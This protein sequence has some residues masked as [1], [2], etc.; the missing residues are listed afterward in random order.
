[1]FQETRMRK[2][3]F[4][5]FILLG[6]SVGVFAA[7]NESTGLKIVLG[8]IGAVAGAAIGGALTGIGGR[9]SRSHAQFDETDGLAAVQDEQARNYWLDRGRLTS[10]P[11]LPHR[12]DNDPHGHE[13]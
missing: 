10:S 4:V 1:M 12:D 6:S 7:L 2:A 5:I 11:G 8:S 3:L 9:L 13:P